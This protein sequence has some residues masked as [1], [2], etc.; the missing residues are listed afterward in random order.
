MGSEID[1]GALYEAPSTQLEIKLAEIWQDVLGVENIGVNDDFFD[2]GGNSLTATIMISRIH[3][4]LNVEVPMKEVFKNSTVKALSIYIEQSSDSR[5]E[6]I[7][8]VGQRAYYPLSAAQKR[9]Y[10]LNKMDK[11]STIYNIPIGMFIEGSLDI[12]RFKNVLQQLVNRHESFRTS[13]H[14]HEDEPVQK[15]ADEVLL[16]M[17]YIEAAE[18]EVSDICKKF[19]RPFD[20]EA[21]PLLRVC[22]VRLDEQKHVFL[23]DMHHIISDG[24]S[25]RVVFDEIAGLYNGETL[26]PL[27]IHYKDY[28]VWQQENMENEKMKK[29]E[30]YWKEVFSGEIPVMELATDY[31]RPPVQS[32]EGAHERYTVDHEILDGLRRLAA[33]NGATLFMVLLSAYTVLLSKYSGQEDIVVGTPVAGRSH[34]ELE[35][36]VGMFVNTLALR[37]HPSKNKTFREYLSEV[38][39][40]TLSAFEN[41][42]YQFEDLVEKVVVKRDLSRNPI[43]DTMFTLQNIN[44]GEIKID[45][46]HFR[47]YELEYKMT[48]FDITLSAMELGDNLELGLEY[49][50][51]LYSEDTAKRILMHYVTLLRDIVKSQD[52]ELDELNILPEMDRLRLETFNNTSTEYPKDKSIVRLFEEQAE[53]T[54]DS[55]ALVS[56]IEVI[57]YKELNRRANRVARVLVENGVKRDSIVGIISG[58]T[59]EMT[60]GIL[61]IL[62]AGGAYLPLDH[63]YPEERTLYMLKDSNTKVLLLD[64]KFKEV[65]SFDGT[66]IE[67]GFENNE[68]ID[69]SNVGINV[70]W[71]DLAYVMYTSGSTGQPKGVEIIHRNVVR[72]VKNTNYIV[73]GKEDRILQT[74]APVFDAATFEVWGALLNGARLY[75]VDED[76]LMDAHKL[77]AHI[78]E[79][80]ITILWLT[81]S[82]FNQLSEI[83]PE[84]FCTLRCLIVGGDVLSVRHINKVRK[85]C[86]SLSVI[87]GYGPT[88]NTTFSVCHIINKDYER[89]IPIGKP[90]SNS[91]AYIVNGS[92]RLQPIGVA[93]ELCLSGDGL[94]RGYLNQ[95][96]LTKEKFV[97]NPFEKGCLMYR[98]GDRARWLPEGTIEFLGRMDSQVKIRGYR[99]EI[100]E[101]EARLSKYSEISECV[102]VAGSDNNGNRY[103]IAYYVSKEAI[104]L[105]ELRSFMSAALPDYMVPAY[106][107]H[108]DE[109]PLNQNGKID[110]GA[111]PVIENQ[112]NTGSEY[113]PPVTALEK[114]LAEIW[115]GVLGTE[116]VGLYDN[117]FELGGH[118]LKATILVSR[119]HRELNVEVPV[120]EIFRNATVKELSLYIGQASD[121][122]FVYIEEAER[123]DF[124][125]LSA[126]QK[127]LYL[128]NGIDKEQTNYN[129]PMCM[130]IEGDINCDRFKNVLNDIVG[131]HE[132]FRTSFHMIENEPVQKIADIAVID[133]EYIEAGENEAD[134]IIKRFIRPF[135][136]EVVPLM[137]ACLIK[138]GEDRHV[139]LIDMHHIISDGTSMKVIFDEITRLY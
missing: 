48:K 7:R 130:N 72:L 76:V 84:M 35:N 100:G 118:S 90:I 108:L 137:R 41:Q 5:F 112:I 83:N 16:S 49:C 28:S 1:T 65:F 81:S 125:P 136:L 68:E 138:T 4:E 117:F 42:D 110:R 11:D 91:R 10:L 139:F 123:R 78:K 119:I 129:I 128:L 64:R 127:R 94:G 12:E 45:Q 95:P 26:E 22:L 20:L 69:S 58:R 133:V 101:V 34:A 88:E 73:I 18:Y 134:G 59:I 121:S 66:V 79:H 82:L 97:D 70:S 17:E 104:G 52:S 75:L 89:S 44:M 60:A 99:I 105:S 14:M 87:N 47:P 32:F 77:G 103:L 111:L 92:N 63:K 13:F 61:G 80:R 8:C 53:K 96:E 106:F 19:I 102:V 39:Q 54:P 132:A 9:L 57:T 56:G 67:F 3:K 15:I 114:K 122:K 124:Y 25:M 85:L 126:A 31:P 36:I 107:V 43:F 33:E 135:D 120:T 38:K 71:E 109:M 21:A 30:L 93:G 113:V 131:R 29:Q 98:T 46:I 62:K 74:G 116:H 27:R 40:S 2:L 23:I 24:T 37:N 6:S 86:P 115:Q 51:R 50:T 55:V